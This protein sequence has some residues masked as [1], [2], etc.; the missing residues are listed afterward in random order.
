MY[1]VF[2]CILFSSSGHDQYFG[3]LAG[4]KLFSAIIQAL[5]AHFYTHEGLR[6]TLTALFG[7]KILIE[8]RRVVNDE[9][10][11]RHSRQVDG[12]F[13]GVSARARAHLSLAP[14]ASLAD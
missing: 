4:I 5:S 11:G 13:P 9:A 2:L 14:P 7:L 1:D 12:V 6:V 10:P 8:A 3:I